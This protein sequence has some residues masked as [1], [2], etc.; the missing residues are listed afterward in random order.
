M[1]TLKTQIKLEIGGVLSKKFDD[2]FEMI[3]RKY[4]IDHLDE[5]STS[6]DDLKILFFHDIVIGFEKDTDIDSMKEELGE[7]LVR[8][9]LMFCFKL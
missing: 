9:K 4:D 6:T 8:E 1:K 2:E 3:C 5:T 7:L